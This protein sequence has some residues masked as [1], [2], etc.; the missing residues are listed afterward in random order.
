MYLFFSGVVCSTGNK[1]RR[2]KGNGCRTTL[3]FFTGKN[4]QICKLNCMTPIICYLNLIHFLLERHL[5]EEQLSWDHS[6]SVQMCLWVT[7]KST[8]AGKMIIPGAVTRQSIESLTVAACWDA[9]IS[10]YIPV[11]SRTSNAEQPECR[12]ATWYFSFSEF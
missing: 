9:Q 11:Q 6:Q 3:F 8:S 2:G 1:M 4:Y 5:I 7:P 10:K 12:E